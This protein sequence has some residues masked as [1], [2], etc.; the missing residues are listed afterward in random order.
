MEPIQHDPSHCEL[1]QAAV[2]TH[3]DECWRCGEPGH[4]SKNCTKPQI[5]KSAQIK[6]VESQFN[7]QLSYQDFKAQYFNSSDNNGLSK[8]DLN[9][10]K[11]SHVS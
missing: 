2:P 4:F 3:L 7:D 10:S 6:E 5:N 9:I 1:C 11:N 8:D